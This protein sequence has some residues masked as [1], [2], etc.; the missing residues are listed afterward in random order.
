MKPRTPG[1]WLIVATVG[2][3][4]LLPMQAL[5]GMTPEEVK[6]FEGYKAKAEK[7]DAA[8]QMDL[9]I[10]FREGKGVSADVVQA[11]DWCRRSAVQ[12]NALVQ[13]ALGVH[14]TMGDGVP[15]DMDEGRKWVRKAAEQ[16]LA[17]AQVNLGMDLLSEQ[18]HGQQIKDLSVSKSAIQ[19]VGWFRKAAEQGDSRGQGM[20]GAC[21]LK[22]WGI[23]KDPLQGVS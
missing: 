13:N 6:A 20:L 16:G 2:L 1:F 22:G 23:P 11:V 4:A 7:G 10:C 18:K 9:S 8:A 12:G 17:K 5:A 21:Y 19:A 15:Q 14:Y 3:L